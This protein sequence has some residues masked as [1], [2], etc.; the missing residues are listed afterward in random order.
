MKEK[1]EQIRDLVNELLASFEPVPVVE[2]IEA[3]PEDKELNILKELLFSDKWPNAVFQAQIADDNSE[4]DKEERAEGIADIILPPYGGKKFLD[5]GCGEGHVVKHV[6]KE[7]SLA[8]GYDI[9]T[10]S[11]SQLV[12]DGESEYLLTTD[13]NKVRDK[14]PYDLILL[15]D[16]F[17]HVRNETPVEVLSKAKSL[18]ADEGKIYM[19]CHPWCS[20]HG[21]HAYRQVNKA[22][23]HLVFSKEELRTL[24]VEL[25]ENQ[26]VYFPLGT[27]TKAI[28]EAGLVKETEHEMN[29]QDVEPFFEQNTLVKNR[30][31]KS[32]GISNWAFDPPVFQM[33][34]CFV[35]F[36]LRKK[37]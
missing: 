2:K 30:I 13:M 24:G 27:Y 34:Q 11:K 12:W 3:S 15:Y 17:D 37:N 8:V 18:L 26:K 1:L 22:F 23:V 19:R 9:E 35:D 29:S 7:A 33:S 36:I 4:K 10:P 32:F 31:M 6:A 21:G 5:F 14:G 28:N 25:E 20:R 16:V